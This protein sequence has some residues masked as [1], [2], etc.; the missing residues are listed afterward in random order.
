VKG[1]RLYLFDI[2]G[3]LIASG[4]AGG[5]GMSAAFQAVWGLADGFAGVEFS[6]RTDRAIL[7]DALR[8]TK[9]GGDVFGFDLARFKR[10]YYRRLPDSLVATNGRVLPGV[11]GLLERLADDPDASL[12]LATGNFRH[13]ARM[14]LGHYGL[15]AFFSAGGFGD[16]SEDRAEMVAAAVG[17]FRAHGRHNTIFVIGDTVHDIRSAKANGVVAV[18]VTTGTYSAEALSEAGADIVLVSLDEAKGRII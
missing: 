18:G 8:L 11:A 14:K 9:T 2:D 17:A 4:G 15:D 13:S 10:A 12:G 1:R 16:R 6:G 3:T 7:R 5:K